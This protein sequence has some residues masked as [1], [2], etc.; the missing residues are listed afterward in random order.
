MIFIAFLETQNY[1]QLFICDTLLFVLY[2]FTKCELK[3]RSMCMELFGELKG[4]VVCVCA[5]NANTQ[6]MRMQCKHFMAFCLTNW[7]L[8]DVVVLN[9]FDD[10]NFKL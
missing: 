5:C 3:T 7:L 2:S 9:H 4:I 1:I 10:P 6:T 8:R